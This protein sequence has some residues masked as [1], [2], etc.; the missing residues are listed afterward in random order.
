MHPSP[1]TST[2]LPMTPRELRQ[3]GVD[4]PDVILVSGDAY[5]DSPYCGIAVIGRVL[6]SAGYCV[7]VIAQPSLDTPDD[8]TALG[9][10]RLFWGISAGCVDS[11]VA[12]RTALGKPRKSCDFTPGTVNNRRP[13][14]ATIM[15]CNLVR[16][17]FKNTVPLVIGGIEASLRRI[18]HYDLQS[19]AIRRSILLDAKADI[20][21][22][23]MGEHA[24]LQIAHSLRE[25][26]DI[27]SI[28]GT[29]VLAA[30]APAGYRELASYEAVQ[31]DADAF[32]EMFATFHKTALHQG[33]P[34]FFQQHGARFLIHHPPAPMLSSA[35]LDR[36]HGL[37]FQHDAHPKCRAD[38]EIRALATIRN[39]VTTH[40]GCYGD[41]S[42]CAITVHQGRSIISR[43]MESIL[44]E[45]KHM[46]SQ[47]GFSGIIR[48]L[49]GPTANMYASGCELLSRGTPCQHRHCIGYEGICPKLVHGHGE[50]VEL[51][52]R[53]RALPGVKR[54]FIA[55]GIR[56]DLILADGKHG[57]AYL[58]Q[59]V[60]HHVSGQLKI[61]P[62]HCADAVLRLMN[63]PSAAVTARFASLYRE[64]A[65]AEN[66][67]I[68]LSCYVIAAHPGSTK[69]H[70][71]EFVRFA[72]SNLQFMPEQVQIFTPTPSTVSTAM[73][74]CGRHPLS[75]EVVWSEKSSV[76]KQAQKDTLRAGREMRKETVRSR[77]AGG[78]RK[79]PSGSPWRS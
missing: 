28:S 58:R 13:D 12:N 46:A 9:E 35:E 32:G 4:R 39:S 7:A 6:E 63:K 21:V 23:G 17:Y 54:I 45:V 73:Y 30:E 79:K 53:L 55:S 18:A 11:A 44:S 31:S 19:S 25:Q 22:Y 26:R 66:Q 40:R 33:A 3:R 14:R 36:V 1:D 5:I 2:F 47:K 38:G 70:M 74:H 56:Y 61:A 10:P 69:Q 71:E 29:C 64:M 43:S 48:D 60:A 76:G 72:R 8:I 20:L 34:G 78:R 51:L 52:A 67:H 62:E 49:G 77:P 41:C 42:F 50:Q 24:V 16:R 37:P 59:M 75:G 65:A 15:Y 57:R 27:K 68:H